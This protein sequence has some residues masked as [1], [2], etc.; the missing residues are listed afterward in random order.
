[1]I[2]ISD[3]SYWFGNKQILHDVSLE[4]PVGGVTALIGAN[5]AGKST[6][7]S[8]IARLLQLQSGRI[9]VDGLDVRRAP[10]RAFARTLAILPQTTDGA[11]RLTVSELVRFGRYPHHNGRP[12]A[13]DL[14][15]I[16]EAIDVLDLRSLGERPLD[17]LSGGQRQRAF[18][19][20]VYAQDT[21]YVLLDEPLNNLDIAASRSLMQ[22]LSD[23]AKHH[24]RTVV[25]VLHD[26]NY[27]C[28]Y[29]DMIVTLTKGRLGP[30]GP[31]HDIVTEDLLSEV[32]GTDASV[33]IDGG[34]RLVKV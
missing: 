2:S 24:G 16:E 21:K 22:L 25:V 10:G 31:P 29:A 20:M 12:A 32:F 34:Q 9:F 7:L 3:V 23:L 28:A 17:S 4:I 14:A 19:A 8:L 30:C 6:L 13:K 15:K 1:M 26:I 5:G 33:V 27:A 18:V 11:P